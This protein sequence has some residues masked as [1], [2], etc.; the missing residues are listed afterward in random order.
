MN[1]ISK[2]FTWYSNCYIC[3]GCR[4]HCHSGDGGSG[5]GKS[6]SSSG[7][8]G[9]FGGC[10]GLD[11]NNTPK[12]PNLRK[13]YAN[14]DKLG[15]FDDPCYLEHNN[16]I[17]V[18]ISQI[19]IEWNNYFAHCNIICQTIATSLNPTQAE[20]APS[21]NYD[22]HYHC[23]YASVINFIASDKHSYQTRCHAKSRKQKVGNI[24]VLAGVSLLL[25]QRY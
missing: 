1:R 17:F 4:C 18:A 3:G 21:H 6:S 15:S 10:I 12:Q 11:M 22:F 23:V 14:K 8:G 24:Y 13:Y 16:T 9:S 25:N 7:G 2:G 5:S 19:L 20:I